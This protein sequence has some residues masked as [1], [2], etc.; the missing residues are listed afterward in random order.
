MKRLL[1]LL[2]VLCFSPQAT[3]DHYCRPSYS[4]QASYNYYRAPA[5]YYP[6]YYYYPVVV[7][8]QVNRDRYY[9][10][11]E[12]R[13]QM[14]MLEMWDEL[15]ERRA[16]R[17]GGYTNGNGSSGGYDTVP[18][19]QMPQAATAPQGQPPQKTAPPA[20]PPAT[21]PQTN[22]LTAPLGKTSEAAAKIL[23]ANCVSC[24]DKDTRGYAKLDLTDLDL[25]PMAQRWA[26]FG[27]AV[28]RDMPLAPS[29]FFGEDGKIKQGKEEEFKKWRE[30]HSL[31]DDQ[32][33]ELYKGWIVPARLAIVR[34]K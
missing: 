30:E 29:E 23:K 31:K 13:L 6:A 17:G 4:Y 11:S 20:S 24:H 18:P 26:A 3:A 28:S 33:D 7:E 8:V 2:L 21:A 34:K 32:I 5:Y 25:V 22:R 16:L 1:F 15:K 12:L 14:A 10:L 27:M 9:S 19:N